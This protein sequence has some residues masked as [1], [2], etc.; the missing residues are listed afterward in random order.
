MAGAALV[1][2]HR[3]TSD[4]GPGRPPDLDRPSVPR[5]G[6]RAIPTGRCAQSHAPVSA[7]RPQGSS[8][9]LDSAPR[10]AGCGSRG[11]GQAGRE[12]GTR[13]VLI[14]RRQVSRACPGRDPVLDPCAAARNHVS[15][16]NPGQVAQL[17]RPSTRFS[18]SPSCIQRTLLHP[19]PTAHRARICSLPVRRAIGSI[20]LLHPHSN[21]S[22]RTARG[23]ACHELETQA[24]HTHDHVR[25]R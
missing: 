7:S 11:G 20:V 2:A 25:P 5:S 10:G 22:T 15:A 13:F 4:S 6:P 9:S 19:A 12:N 16:A 1:A 21:P 23:R 14:A 18:T 3:R 17:D 8:P 24:S